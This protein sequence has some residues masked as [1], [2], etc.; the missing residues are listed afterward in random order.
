[1]SETSKPGAA[2]APSTQA[3]LPSITVNMLIDFLSQEEILHKPTAARRSFHWLAAVSRESVSCALPVDIADA[4]LLFVCGE[5]EVAAL[6]EEK[7]T[8]F[9]LVLVDEGH[10]L[11]SEAIERFPER[12]IAIRQRDRFSYFVFQLQSYFTQLLV[13]ENE[14]D[15]IV[16]RQ[17]SLS[18]A[19]NATAMV[20]HNFVF[21]SDS[22]LNVIARSTV[23][24]PPDDLH[25]HIVETGCLTL[26]MIEEK[27]QRLS[28]KGYYIKPP[29][30]FSPYARLSRPLYI[31]HIYFGSLSMSC[32]DAPLTDGLEDLF[33]ILVRHIMP[34]CETQWRA[35][36]KLNVPQYFFFAKMLE[37]AQVTDEYLHSQ[38]EAAHL[39]EDMEFKLIVMNV[40]GEAEP[41]R[42][43]AATQA[44]LRINQGSVSCFSYQNATLVLCYTP[45]S[46]SRLSHI[47]TIE[48]LRKHIYEPFGVES[49]VS[50]VFVDIT[51]LDLAYRQAKI[52]LGLKHTLEQ[53]QFS[54]AQS[55]SKGIY[56]FGDALLYFLVDPSNKDARFMRFCFQHTILEK[57]Y[58]EDQ[59]N[60]TN[61]L[62]LFWF[63]L[64]YGRNA[65][66]VAQ[67]LHMH[68]NTVL[69]H[70]EKI[71]KRFDFDLSWRSAR[72][73]MMLDFRVL[74]LTMSHES[75]EKI[76][77]DV[78]ED[79]TSKE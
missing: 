49:G 38:M 13:W 28:E 18:D 53:E 58:E 16:T 25:R 73:R 33:D 37:H 67:R 62:A 48:D 46:D 78:Q 71:Q 75:V 74:F 34:L 8:A 14:L 77:A 15:R 39:T 76:F 17:G 43:A 54:F 31:N 26:Q 2:F 21:I 10:A 5:D 60:G 65:T 12:L 50:E 27:R 79:P 19:L 64:Y 32:H 3:N 59:Q 6:L 24:E 35:Q 1:M 72:D 44:A 42:A 52:A 23:L 69:Y 56:L 29:S 41:E 40:D 51:N 68:R 57:L 63:Y 9:A 47:K 11:P 55:E 36:L 66:A 4:H 61:C 45:P 22:N 70:I 30:A 20:V 7:P